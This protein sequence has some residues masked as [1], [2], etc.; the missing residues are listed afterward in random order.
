[1]SDDIDVDSLLNEIEE[2]GNGIPMSSEE[3]TQQEPAQAFDFA[4]FEFDWNGQKVKPDS[5]DKAKTWMQQGYNYSQRAA[6]LNKRQGEFD[7]RTKH[8][9]KFDEVD[10]F[11][12]ENPQW[13]EHVEKAWDSRSQQG[14][15]QLDPSLE[16]IIK[17]LQEKLSQFE[18]FFG[19]LQ[20]ERQ[21]EVIKKEDQELDAEIDSI[22]KQYPNI[23]LNAVDQ[24]G[25]TLEMRVLDHAQQIGT[26]QFRAAF[27]DY[28]H[29]DLLKTAKASS[30]EANVKGKQA[31]TRQGILGTSSTPKKVIQ[32]AQNVRGKSYDSLAE[33]ALKE[34]GLG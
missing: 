34:F 19:Q 16:P 10:A 17:P 15:P 28:L 26:N 12:R 20:E 13:W 14:Q 32:T 5:F 31:Q 29:D 30:L 2:P 7:Q 9:A 18:T 1:M 22:R 6:D 11:A 25:R 4:Q 27:R 23:D 21:Q 8:Y 24:S 33:E 3:P